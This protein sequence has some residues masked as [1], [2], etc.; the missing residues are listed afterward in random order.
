MCHLGFFFH[1]ID[2]KYHIQIVIY[3]LFNKNT[4]YNDKYVKLKHNGFPLD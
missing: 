4:G 2:L 3:V 1:K